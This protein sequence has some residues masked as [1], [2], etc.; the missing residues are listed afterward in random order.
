MRSLS[1][2]ERQLGADHPSVAA[3]LNNLALLYEAQGKYSEAEPLYLRA[4]QIFK[5]ALGSGHPNTVTVRQNY[6]IM[7]KTM[8][9]T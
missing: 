6:E 3:S 7:C 8:E 5:K 2:L 4:I 1:I 9:E